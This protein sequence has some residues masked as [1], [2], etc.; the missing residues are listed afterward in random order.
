MNKIFNDMDETFNSIIENEFF[1]RM[2][3]GRKSWEI[4]SGR[5][6]S[7]EIIRSWDLI[8]LR[9]F[10]LTFSN[11]YFANLRVYDTYFYSCEFNNCKFID[12]K[13]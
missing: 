9:F 2:N 6:F 10:S 1:E 8:D 3:D 5:D 4:I 12:T 11:C 13:F 7:H